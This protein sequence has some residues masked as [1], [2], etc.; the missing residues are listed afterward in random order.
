MIEE[1]AVN[2]RKKLRFLEGFANFFSEFF[3][4]FL[5]SDILS[6]VKISHMALTQIS[7]PLCG[8]ASYKEIRRSYD[9]LYLTDEKLFTLVRCRQ[10][11]LFYLNPQPDW[12]ELERY[13]PKRYNPYKKATESSP[14]EKISLPGKMI[15][16]ASRLKK[17]ILQP[18]APV[19][20]GQQQKRILDIGCGSGGF[21]KNLKD[22]YPDKEYYGVEPSP[23]AAEAASSYGISVQVNSVET[24][25]LEKDFF[26]TIFLNHVFEH[27]PKPL[28]ALE[29]IKGILK[30]GGYL[31]IV[32]P[33]YRSFSARIFGDYWFPFDIPRHLFQ[34]SPKTL[35]AFLDKAGFSVS[36]ISFDKNPKHFLK[37]I[38]AATG[39]RQKNI[40][41]EGFNVLAWWG[42][43]PFSFLAA[44]L[45]RS[46]VMQ[47]VAQK[48]KPPGR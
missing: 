23:E 14:P 15:R 39:K 7:C 19:Y 25:E 13:Y 30:P 6:A 48:E 44:K 34:F 29:R 24:M 33:N 8:N 26:D 37:S 16:S 38:R 20:L 43:K 31:V 42:L 27:L 40:D 46:S 35:S 10:C 12:E 11:G 28:E 18:K 17:S 1:R 36:Y 4:R 3:P 32:V 9:R 21:L 2:P 47:T 45:G 22:T 5:K 41:D